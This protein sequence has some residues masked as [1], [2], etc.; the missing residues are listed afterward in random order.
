MFKSDV[1]FILVRWREFLARQADQRDWNGHGDQGRLRDQLCGRA[2]D[3]DGDH[4]LDPSLALFRHRRH[5]NASSPSQS[6]DRLLSRQFW[7]CLRTPGGTRRRRH[8]AWQ[9]AGARLRI[10]RRRQ[11]GR[12]ADPDRAIAGRAVALSDAEPLLRDRQAHRHR[13]VVVRQHAAGVGA[14]AGHRRIRPP[15]RH[16]RLSSMRIT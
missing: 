2:A 11:P 6:A 12:A 4:A 9:R 13:L 3:A 10:A 14:G 15:S 7:Q 8:L 16:L 1:P 5:R